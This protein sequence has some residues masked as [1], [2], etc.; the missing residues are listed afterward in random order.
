MFDEIVDYDR[1]VRMCDDIL[2]VLRNSNLLL[3][4]WQY[5]LPF[6]SKSFIIASLFVVAPL[7]I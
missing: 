5:F 2:C 3:V 1:C 6:M 4:F 7:Q